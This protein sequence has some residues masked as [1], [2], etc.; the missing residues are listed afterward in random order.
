M[1]THWEIEEEGFDTRRTYQRNREQRATYWTGLCEWISKAE[2]LLPVIGSCG[3]PW[4][5]DVDRCLT[6]AED[7][8]GLSL[9]FQLWIW[10]CD[11]SRNHCREWLWLQGSGCFWFLLDLS[12]NK[13]RDP[14]LTVILL[15]AAG[16]ERGMHAFYPKGVRSEQTISTRISTLR[17][18]LRTSQDNA[19]LPNDSVVQKPKKISD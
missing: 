3:E 15:V 18:H 7:S 1:D 6:S 4:H 13:F 16:V 11:Y 8:V 5:I 9:A 2:M 10:L 19:I 12:P 17:S 14:T